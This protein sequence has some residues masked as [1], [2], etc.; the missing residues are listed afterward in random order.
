MRQQEL[1]IKENLKSLAPELREQLQKRASGGQAPLDEAKERAAWKKKREGAKQDLEEKAK[2][3]SQKE[4]DA[5]KKRNE[6]LS[7]KFMKSGSEEKPGEEGKVAGKPVVSPLKSGAPPGAKLPAPP[8]RAFK[9]GVE[10]SPTEYGN[11]TATPGEAEKEA[12]E[13]EGRP[14]G[15]GK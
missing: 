9:K 6:V 10:K 1:E 5:T 8:S 7:E 3:M 11:S 2:K 15:R 13:Y 12:I 14:G 4:I